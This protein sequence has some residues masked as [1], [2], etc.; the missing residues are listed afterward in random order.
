MIVITDTRGKMVDRHCPRLL[1]R[2]GE[3]YF[4]E[5]TGG[6]CE[7]VGACEARR[8]SSFVAEKIGMGEVI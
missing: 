6:P 2:L 7:V 4:C 8:L 1:R 5:H 3:G